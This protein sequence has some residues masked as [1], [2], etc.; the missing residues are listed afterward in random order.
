M[1]T[2]RIVESP[3]KGGFCWALL[4]RSFFMISFFFGGFIYLQREVR[5]S[6][7]QQI[8]LSR[9]CIRRSWPTEETIWL[10]WRERSG[11]DLRE[12]IEVFLFENDACVSFPPHCFN[13]PIY[14]CTLARISHRLLPWWWRRWA[15]ISYYQGNRLG[16]CFEAIGRNIA[17][18]QHFTAF[19]DHK[20]VGRT[21]GQ[22]THA[23]GVVS[24]IEAACSRN[25]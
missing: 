23:Q 22:H 6:Q 8:S 16:G 14:V 5:S 18:Y 15:H 2:K 25:M 3:D 13:S 7:A 1:H 20:R 9:A 11:E 12:S 17:W 21:K 4:R 19:S 24:G 10:E